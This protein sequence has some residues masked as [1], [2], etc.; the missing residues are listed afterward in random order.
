MKIKIIRNNK[1]D[2]EAF[3]NE[4]N[5]FIKNKK[6]VDIKIAPESP[7]LYESIFILYDEK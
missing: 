2:P 1:D 5:S 6:V 3:E 7:C 4:I